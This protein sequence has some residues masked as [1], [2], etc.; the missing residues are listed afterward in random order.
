VVAHAFEPAPHLAL[1]RLRVALEGPRLDAALAAGTDPVASAAL[2]LRAGQLVQ[3]QLRARYSRS[4]RRACESIQ[5]PRLPTRGAAVPV[6]RAAVLQARPALLALADDLVEVP[7]PRPRGV[8]LALQL[9]RD[10]SG[11]LYR[12]WAPAE[13]HNAAERAR[14]AL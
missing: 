12:S 8:A 4:L 10:G 11:P 1:L 7:R 14:H 5:R 2:A 13:L 3:P 6:N 9:L